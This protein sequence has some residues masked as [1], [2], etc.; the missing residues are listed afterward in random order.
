MS[1]NFSENQQNISNELQ[2]KDCGALLKYAPGTEKLACK[3]C[4]A[5]NYIG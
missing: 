1:D 3:Y 5:Q 4:G 2:C